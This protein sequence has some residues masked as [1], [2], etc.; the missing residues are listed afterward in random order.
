VGKKIWM[1]TLKR[2]EEDWDSMP[3]YKGKFHVRCSK[4]DCPNFGVL[5]K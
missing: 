2:F 1:R 5:G 4:E 3:L